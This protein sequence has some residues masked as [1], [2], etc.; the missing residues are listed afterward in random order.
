LRRSHGAGRTLG[1]GA[2]IV[3]LALIVAACGGGSKSGAGSTAPTSTAPSSKGTTAGAFPNFKIAYDTSIDFLD[4]GLSYTVQA[5]QI[6][7]NVY[8]P[9]IGYKHVSGPDGAT[10]VPYLAEALPKVS[11]DGKTYTMTLRKGLTYSDG[12]PVKASDFKAT[13]ERDFRID[14]P[15]VGF[16]GNIVGADKFGAT[17]KGHISGITAD[18]ASGQITIQ[19]RRRQA[20]FLNI[21]ATEFAAPLPAGT[22]DRDMSNHPAPATG[23]YV[24]Q[25]YKAG[26]LGVLVRNPTFDAAKLGNNVPAGNP[27]KIT[28]DV[29]GSDTTAL[30]RV[31]KGQDDYNFWQPP[32]SRLGELQ[33]KY[34]SQMRLYIP[35][36]TY[37][38]FLNHRVKPFS[39]KSVRQAVNYGIDRNELIRIYGG[40]ATSTQNLLPPTYAQ[41]K[42]VSQYS[43]DLGKAQQLV[44]ASGM[45]S[46]PITVWGRQR[47]PDDKATAYLAAQLRKMGFTNVKQRIVNAAIY[48]TVV[49]NQATKAQVGFADWFQDY[50]HPLDWFDVLVNGNR[51]TSTHNNNYGNVDIP[52]VNRTI[53]QLKAAP[54]LNAQVNAKWARV[55]KMLADDAAIA[56][57]L[58]RQ[59]VDFFNAGMN[60]A[61]N[62]YVNH[63]MYAFDY[64]QACKK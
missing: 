6:I 37:Y 2:L 19:L 42:K 18:D 43:Y 14:S 63:I 41:Y 44:K 46:Q 4:P 59:Y 40:L 33:S 64:A 34:P 30:D 56:A 17:K 60:L 47:Y 9:L 29:I 35:S 28:I 54:V 5:T 52:R 15:G 48:W 50:P 39:N 24:I 49:G 38:F 57:F 8:L 10:L 13:I 16:F 55:D 31:I 11:S 3:A 12:K 23:P 58:N 62:C 7:W 45:A 1:A 26:K 36:N 22:P 27:D 32:A 61:G 53:E 25:S 21:L 20:D 51:I